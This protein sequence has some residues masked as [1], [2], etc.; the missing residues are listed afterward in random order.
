MKAAV[1]SLFL[2]F[3]TSTAIAKPELKGSPDDLCQFLYL[4]DK[5]V[6]I[7]GGAEEKVY[8]DKTIMSNRNEFESV[9]SP[10]LNKNACAATSRILF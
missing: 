7:N 5:V 6:T 10:A 9:S 2:I 8:S 1:F 3:I 4:S